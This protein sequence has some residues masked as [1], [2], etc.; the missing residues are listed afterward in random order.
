[1]KTAADR[2]AP[3]RAGGPGSEDVWHRIEQASFAVVG[4][5]TPEGEPRSS[6]VVYRA[7]DGRLRVVTDADS[8]KARH[9]APRGMVAVTVPIRRG[10][11]LSL[12][13]PIPP[14][15]ISFRGTATVH[16]PGSPEALHAVADLGALIPES[17][18]S[19]AAMIEIVPV[20]TF[21]TYGIGTPLRKLADPA[22]AGGRAPVG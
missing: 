15:T 12:L 21:L 4:Y 3:P 10:G 2:V 8:W 16:A 14:A 19:D 5:V 18:R 11:L 13:A 22:A 17:R 7:G 20:G 6:G 1:M 9:L